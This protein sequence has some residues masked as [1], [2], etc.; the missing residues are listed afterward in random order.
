MRLREA[1][2]GEALDLVPDP[3]RQLRSHPMRGAG[4]LDEAPVVGLDRLQRAL[5]AHRPAQALR[6]GGGEAGEGDRH[7]EDLLLVDDRAERLGQHRP[8]RL[9]LIGDLVAGVFALA[10]AALYVWMHGA[11]LDRAGPDQRHLHGDVVEVARLGARQHLHLGAALDL[12]D[13]GRLG[14][15][16][17]LEG[18]LVAIVDPREVE[19]LAAGQLQFVDAALDRREHP[20]PEQVDLQQA[21]VGAG[22]LVPLDDLAAAHRRRHDRADVDERVGRDHHPARVLGG[23]AGQPERVL[24]EPEQRPPARRGGAVGADRGDHV[25]GQLPGRVVKAG[26]LRHLLDLRRRQAEGLAEVA[27]DAARPVGREGGDEGRAV[28]AVDVVDTGDQDLADVAREIEV[29]VG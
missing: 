1:E 11:A 14:A 28:G 5:A 4:A 13:A 24:A 29:D 25:D 15:A 23:V 17:R 20:E 7:F 16:D 2:A 26:D 9:V 12:E 18:L 10:L 8:Q 27:D 3:L 22:V 6:L 21:G 19:P